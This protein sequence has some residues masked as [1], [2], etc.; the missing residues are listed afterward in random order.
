MKPILYHCD[1]FKGMMMIESDS[2]N[3]IIADLPYGTTRNKW[4]IVINPDKLWN[5][6]TRIL[7]QD[8]IVILFGSGIFTATM[9]LSNKR[10][11]RY[12]L[13]YEKT[14][15]TGHLNAKKQPLRSHE[16][17]MVFCRTSKG[18]YNPQKTS[19]HKRKVSLAAH[20]LSG[21]NSDNYNSSIKK[22]Y[23][24]TERYPR[25]VWKFKSDKQ[26]SALHP[27]QK[28]VALIR[29]LVKTYS[30]VGDLVLDNVAGSGTTGE[31]CMLEERNCILIENDESH[32]KTIEE[33]LD[34]K[35]VNI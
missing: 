6:Y 8:G 19:G 4:D 7:K 30:N 26:K 3:L 10:H 28:P 32:I 9:I 12:S 15:A 16:D 5:F 17:M 20:S 21:N 29:E 34:I 25:S 35:A 2:V 24:S 11:F 27:T 14:S 33:R 1:T 18:V 13:V 23:D 31:A 22:D